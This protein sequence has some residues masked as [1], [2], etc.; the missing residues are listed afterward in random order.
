MAACRVIAC[1]VHAKLQIKAYLLVL[2]RLKA[3]FCP[4]IAGFALLA[5]SFGGCENA[6]ALRSPPRTTKGRFC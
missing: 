5:S 6:D 3:Y 1:F 2:L 4:C